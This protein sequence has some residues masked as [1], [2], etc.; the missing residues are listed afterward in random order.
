[1]W[2]F[3]QVSDPHL[4]SQAHNDRNGR[5]ESVLIPEVISCLRHDLSELQ[6]DFL[7]V[8]GDIARCESRDAVFAARDF[9]DSLGFPYYPMGGRSDFQ[10]KQ[11][12]QW[13]TEAFG[14]CLPG[15]QT[16]YSFTHQDI[17][18]CVLDPWWRWA[19]G[20]EMPFSEGDDSVPNWVI[21]IS[22]LAWLEA[23]LMEHDEEATIIA[24]HPPAILPQKESTREAVLARGVLE[25]AAAL[26]ELL[27]NH[28][29]VKLVISGSAHTHYIAKEAGLTQIVT[30]SL[31]QYPVEFR[32]IHVHDD[33]FEI[34]TKGL[35]NSLYA[36]QTMTREK[37]WAR[38]EDEDRY[39][40][41][42]F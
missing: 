22:Q 2:R 37:E 10:Y 24:M 3:I 33:R 20:T 32:D 14:A 12:R 35:S 6:P 11:S 25:N 23:D 28:A 18:F 29:Q 36:S 7:V 40:V 38:G 19:D 30:G 21:P 41:I 1:M 9:M 17:H 27:E 39:A 26:L 42:P 8:T 34:H 16:S 4:G 15:A 13:F 5:I 31:T